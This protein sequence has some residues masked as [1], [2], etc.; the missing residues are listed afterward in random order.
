MPTSMMKRVMLY[1]VLFVPFFDIVQKKIEL[2]HS[3]L[4]MKKYRNQ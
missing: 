1:I 2:I 3:G 4:E